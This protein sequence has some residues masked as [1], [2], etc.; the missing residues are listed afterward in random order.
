MRV[1]TFRDWLVWQE[2]AES[3]GLLTH[4]NIETMNSACDEIGRMIHGLMRPL[5]VHT[6]PPNPEKPFEQPD[7]RS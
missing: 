1:Q 5:A 6:D 4:W 7:G 3:S 2:L